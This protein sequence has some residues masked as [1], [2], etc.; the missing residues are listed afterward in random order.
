MW[1]CVVYLYV[2]VDLLL[3]LY[4]VNLLKCEVDFVIMFEWFECGF[5]VVMKLCDY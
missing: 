1:F 4:F 3:V 5:Y 2:M